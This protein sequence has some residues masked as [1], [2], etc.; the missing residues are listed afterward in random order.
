MPI[1][2][3]IIGG[4][5]LGY[6]K[7]KL[8][9]PGKE[10]EHGGNTFP[11]QSSNKVDSPLAIKSDSKSLLGTPIFSDMILD[12][13]VDQIYMDAILIEVTRQKNIIKTIV[14]GKDTTIKEY[15]NSGDFFI[16]VKGALHTFKSGNYPI[17]DVNTMI[18]ILDTN[19]AI[20]VI[21]PYLRLFGI[22]NIVIEEFNFPQRE[23]YENTQLFSFT[24]CSDEPIQ[25][26]ANV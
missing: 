13:G 20:K 12:N 26:V 4:F 19:R 21:C 18:S 25:L 24:A 14:V 10:M 16:S 17:G 3:I 15:I 5:G 7:P 6:L 1:G 8:Y 9:K 11:A 2:E 22:Y 23:G